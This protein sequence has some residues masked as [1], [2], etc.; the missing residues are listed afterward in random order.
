MPS[1]DVLVIEPALTDLAYSQRLTPAELAIKYKEYGTDFF[2]V[3]PYTQK[4]QRQLRANY[5]N[6]YK[7]A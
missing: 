2:V 7:K 6:F 4:L 1:N 5:N 3:A